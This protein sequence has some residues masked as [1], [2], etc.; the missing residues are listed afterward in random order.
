MYI[1]SLYLIPAELSTGPAL[2]EPSAFFYRHISVDG[3][4]QGLLTGW[5]E[6]L[7]PVIWD[8]EVYENDNDPLSYRRS[9][10]KEDLILFRAECLCR[11]QL[12]DFLLFNCLAEDMKT[13]EEEQNELQSLIKSLTKLIAEND[14]SK[15][16]VCY[17]SE[18]IDEH[19]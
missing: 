11:K 9:V 18:Y 1:A 16:S 7:I 13:L 14:F 12:A 8:C 3:V 4:E 6:T 17:F 15:F 2:L 5:N 19:R 10:S